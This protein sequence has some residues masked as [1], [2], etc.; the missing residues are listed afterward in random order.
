MNRFQ[1][2]IDQVMAAGERA[3]IASDLIVIVPIVARTAH[4]RAAL[5]ALSAARASL[6]VAILEL[7]LSD[8]YDE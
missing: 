2:S 7:E 4:Q 3:S 1:E 8:L 6:E 5:A